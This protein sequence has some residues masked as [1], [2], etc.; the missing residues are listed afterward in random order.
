M[1]AK[2]RHPCAALQHRRVDPVGQQAEDGVPHPRPP[3]G[4]P[5][6]ASDRSSVLASTRSADRARPGS[7][8]ARGSAGDE[9]ATRHVVGS[10]GRR[11]SW[12]RFRCNQHTSAAGRCPAIGRQLRI[13]GHDRMSRR[14]FWIVGGRGLPPIGEDRDRRRPTRPCVRAVARV[15]YVGL[16]GAVAQLERRSVR[17]AEV[18]G[19]IPFRSTSIRSSATGSVP[20]FS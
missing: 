19:S 5:R 2:T 7:G 11:M 8:R 18:E 16:G 6:R 3:R 9:D 20:F 17:N 15:R 13:G 10:D 4:A 1:L 14:G 12:D